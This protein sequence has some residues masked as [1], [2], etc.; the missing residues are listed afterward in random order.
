MTSHPWV[1]LM[2]G[3]FKDTA[4]TEKAFTAE[5]FYRTGDIGERFPDGTL[6]LIDRYVC[7]AVYMCVRA[8]CVCC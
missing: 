4:T 6:R 5:G 1:Q 3:Y 8:L 2:Q 7:C